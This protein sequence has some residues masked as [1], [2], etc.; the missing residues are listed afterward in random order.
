M[1]YNERLSKDTNESIPRF[2]MCCLQGKV[3]LHF[4][5]DPP[6]LLK[7][8]LDGSHPDSSHFK[9][10]IKTYNMMFS[11]TSMGGK[12]DRKIND[13]KGPYIYRMGGQNVHQIG[14][15]LPLQGDTP[16][17]AQLY[18]YDIQNK[19]KNRMKTLNSNENSS[20]IDQK[21]VEDRMTMFDYENQ[22]IKAFRMIRDR[23]K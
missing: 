9:K 19:V 17:F 21:I 3:K 1:W 14:S 8:L 16:K 10:F 5:R 6:S 18:I 23:F 15:I 2:G 12:I 7:G 22:I 4:Q 13:G 11:F 20:G